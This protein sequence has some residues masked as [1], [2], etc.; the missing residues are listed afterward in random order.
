MVDH[1]EKPELQYATS[2]Q[3]FTLQVDLHPNR[4]IQFIQ[5]MMFVLKFS[6]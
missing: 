6:I 3:V 2:M 5:D 4:Q 1:S